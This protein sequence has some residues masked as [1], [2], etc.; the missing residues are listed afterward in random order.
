MRITPKRR[1][2]IVNVH[3]LRLQGQAIAKIAEHFSISPATV[4]ADLQLADSH[5]STVAA[6]A[7]DDLL[8]ESL[9][10]LQLR[11][12]LAIKHDLVTD[13]AKRLTPVEYLRARDAQENQLNGLAREVRRTVHDVHQR[14]AQ[15]PD[16]PDLY[17]E[18]EASQESAENA[19]ELAQ[20][21]A[22]S[23][24]SAH[25]NETISSPEQEIVP[26][27]APQ[28]K[29]PPK[30]TLPPVALP[31]PARP[32]PVPKAPV[33]APER[34]SESVPDPFID[35]AVALFPHLKGQSHDEILRFLKQ[36]TDPARTH[37]SSTRAVYAEA[38]G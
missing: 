31:R 11:L 21:S 24:I 17:I 19:P 9:Q 25:P 23:S 4:R 13:N 5:W 7:A 10:L 34:D 33:L 27:I 20:T 1:R 32:R 16:Q 8:L 38:A 15:R 18:D 36:F 22:K 26:E 2:R 37:D 12:S 30:T 6:G 28:E 14:A 29:N 35:E 3:Y